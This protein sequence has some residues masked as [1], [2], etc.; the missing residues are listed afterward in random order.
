MLDLPVE[1]IIWEDHY[2]T[3]DWR[4]HDDED[5]AGVVY[6][7]SIGY[8]LKEN[9]QRVVLVQNINTENNQVSGTITILKRTIKKRT[10]VRD[11]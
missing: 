9:R 5:V 4:K 7:T 2:S 11:A 1:E 6:V 3:D 10:I 8:R